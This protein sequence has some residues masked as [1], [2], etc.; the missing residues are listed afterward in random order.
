VIPAERR[1][2][3]LGRVNPNCG[4]RSLNEGVPEF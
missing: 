1:F 3:L 2:R 4:Y